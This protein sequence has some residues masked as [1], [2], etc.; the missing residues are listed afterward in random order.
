MLGKVGERH[1][2]ENVFL[3]VSAQS[4]L[5]HRFWLAAVLSRFVRLTPMLLFMECDDGIQQRLRDDRLMQ[6][7]RREGTFMKDSAELAS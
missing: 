5:S 6:D 2:R 7:P 4:W 3:R 1:Y